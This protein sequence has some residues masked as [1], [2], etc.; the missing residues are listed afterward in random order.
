M[1]FPWLVCE[2]NWESIGKIDHKEVFGAAP[3][4]SLWFQFAFHFFVS[5]VHSVL[6]KY[7]QTSWSLPMQIYKHTIIVRCCLWI[8]NSLQRVNFKHVILYTHLYATSE[9]FDGLQNSQ[10]ILVSQLLNPLH[11]YC[12]YARWQLSWFGHISQFYFP[13]Q[14]IVTQ[15]FLTLM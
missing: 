12:T 4:T 11:I 2:S 13:F 6:G 9:L 1:Y 3:K 15:L 7:L 14:N 10:Q 5:L 8:H